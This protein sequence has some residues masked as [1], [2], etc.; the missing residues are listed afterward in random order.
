M[1][2]LLSIVLQWGPHRGP[3]T[4]MGPHWGGGGAMDPWGATGGS[5]VSA[6]WPVVGL[7]LLAGAVLLAVYLLQ[8]RPS[9]TDRAMTVL[10]EAYARGDL[11][12]AEFQR[13][14]ARLDGP[15]NADPA[16]SK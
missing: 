12:D 13:R 16:D 2:E 9:D 10:R 14:A 7:L 15:T 3:H 5:A 6:A 4:P 11:D 1:T 8:A